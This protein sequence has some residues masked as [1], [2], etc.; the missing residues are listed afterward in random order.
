MKDRFSGLRHGAIL[1][2]LAIVVSLAAGAAGCART[3]AAT[4]PVSPALD[5]P[6]PPPRVIT[7]IEVE[8]VA[9]E[10]VPEEQPQPLQ[11]LPQPP[12]PRPAPAKTEPPRPTPPVRVDTEPVKPEES[13]PNRTLQTPDSGSESARAIREQLARASAN[14]QKVNYRSLSPNLKEQYDVAKRF[15]QQSEDALKAGNLVYA[16]TLAGKALE[17]AE[18]LPR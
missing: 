16:S 8:A 13:R 17:I 12:P 11:P 9:P 14:L 2:L 5:A 4:Q 1:T 15:M 6:P 10:P 3:R 18:V 7:P